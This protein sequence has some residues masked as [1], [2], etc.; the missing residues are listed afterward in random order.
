MPSFLLR[1]ATHAH[2][3]TQWLLGQRIQASQ[4]S[5]PGE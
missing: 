3:R 4:E 2:A 1:L 5:N